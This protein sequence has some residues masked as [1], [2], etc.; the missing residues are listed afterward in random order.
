MQRQTCLLLACRKPGLGQRLRRRG[1]GGDREGGSGLTHLLARHAAVQ[2]CSVVGGTR[3]LPGRQGSAC[4][5]QERTVSRVQVEFKIGT[6]NSGA[7]IR[8][9]RSRGHDHHHSQQRLIAA[10]AL[11]VE[12]AGADCAHGFYA[13]RARAQAAS[14]A[15]G[16]PAALHPSRTLQACSTTRQRAQCRPCIQA[17]ASLEKPTNLGRTHCWAHQ[18]ASHQPPRS[19]PHT[20]VRPASARHSSPHSP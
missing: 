20:R 3:R 1:A 14:A 12:V 15:I 17:H 4:W 13:L 18:P 2:H 8:P 16:C 19:M 7:Q 9:R 5:R 6:S 11:P 10:G